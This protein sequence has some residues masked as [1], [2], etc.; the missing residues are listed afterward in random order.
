MYISG[1]V[2]ILIPWNM[3]PAICP[4]KNRVTS[5]VPNLLLYLIE[6]KS[7]WFVRGKRRGPGA[8]AG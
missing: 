2:L 4:P 5:N 1:Y 3:F 7:G 8:S 6:N